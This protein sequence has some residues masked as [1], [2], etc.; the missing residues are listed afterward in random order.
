MGKCKIRSILGSMLLLVI[1][2]SVVTA[3]LPWTYPPGDLSQ[4]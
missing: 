1:L 4:E 3:E 2:T